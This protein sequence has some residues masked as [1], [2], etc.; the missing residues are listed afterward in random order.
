ML[1]SHAKIGSGPCCADVK[2]IAEQIG[3]FLSE[4]VDADEEYGFKLK[5]LNM[6]NVEHADG[7]IS[8]THLPVMA[9]DDPDVLIREGVGKTYGDGSHV[10]FIVHE[11]SD[12]R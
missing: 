8:S 12:G 10:I 2:I 11:H 5:P 1:T 6:L 4:T 3:I 9:W 7:V